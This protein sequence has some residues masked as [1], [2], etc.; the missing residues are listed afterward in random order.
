MSGSSPEQRHLCVVAVCYQLRPDVF[1]DRLRSLASR[2]GV[3]LHGVVVCNNAVHASGS[4]SGE[5]E[6]L[7]GS[8]RFLDF[9]GY[10][11]GLERLLAGHPK[12]AGGNVLFVNDTLVTKHAAAC[13]LGRVLGLDAL[14][15]KLRVPA[16]A[17]KVDPYGSICLRNPWSG[18]PSYV[19]TFCFML[20]A[21]AL[22]SLRALL[23]Q[24][25]DDDVLS[26]AALD[27]DAWG[28]RMPA[29]FREHI[30]AHLAYA[31]SPYLWPG[32]TTPG[33]DLLRKKACCV[34]F[35]GR[36]SGAIGSDGAIVPI[37][38]GPRSTADILVR[39]TFS[40]VARSLNRS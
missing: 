11:E 4:M 13:I 40:R 22:P 35:E 26:E 16:M 30:L 32:A 9:S 5:L 27:D 36:L 20:N 31:D 12:T 34:Y 33:S 23:P 21:R 8:N 38:S 15:G 19:T 1:A 17:G 6:F 2:S 3:V 28:R 14:L 25:I 39:E 24:A 37:N 18:H 7:R 10:F 29:V